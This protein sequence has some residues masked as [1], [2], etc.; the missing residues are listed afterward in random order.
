MCMV[1]S[2]LREYIPLGKKTIN[3]GKKARNVKLLLDLDIL[4]FP[5]RNER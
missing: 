3:V 2:F 5:G 1:Y 4:L